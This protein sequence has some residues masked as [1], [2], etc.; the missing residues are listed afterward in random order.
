M[1]CWKTINI[2]HQ[3]GAT[4][5]AIYSIMMFLV[6]FTTTFVFFNLSYHGHFTDKFFW[7]FIL[8]FILLYPIHKIIHYVSLLDYRKHI[9]LLLKIRYRII[10]I[11]HLR[12]KEPIPKHRYMMTLIAPFIVLNSIYLGLIIIYPQYTHYGTLL[13]ASHCSI[14]VLDLLYIKNLLHTPKNAKIEETPRGYEILV[15]PAAH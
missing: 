15:P 3:Y 13:L 2:H 7:L 9:V 6:I 4:R 12:L 10:P 8:A 1:H 5:V 11:V 14:C